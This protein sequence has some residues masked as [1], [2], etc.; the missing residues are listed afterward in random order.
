[1][2]NHA[3]SA[4]FQPRHIETVTSL[5]RV[6]NQPQMTEEILP[7]TVRLVR[8]EIDLNK[9]VDIRHS[10]YARHMPVV[11][12]TLIAPEKSDTE[13]GVVVLLA[14]SKLD[15]SPLGTVRIE[16][17]RYRPLNLEKSIDLPN[18]RRNQSMA[19]VCRLGI[20]QGI[21]G[22]LVKIILV[23]ASFQYCEQNQIQWA[24]V[25]AR[26]PLDRQ[27]AQLMFEDVF[28]GSGYIPLPHMNNV[29]HRVMEFEI[30]TGKSRWTRAQHPMLKF[31]C[32]T[33]HPDIA[34]DNDEAGNDV[35]VLRP[36]SSWGNANAN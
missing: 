16:T 22:R 13:D 15:G 3:T 36:N 10:A 28:P 24:M 19:Q 5:A 9:A 20:T 8:N 35:A 32:D 6:R 29:P 21:V 1:M 18:S 31:F 4:V 25:A 12:D 26:S 14:E 17:N 27:Y 33:Y 11:A 2:L 34:I 30:D 7:F 23:K